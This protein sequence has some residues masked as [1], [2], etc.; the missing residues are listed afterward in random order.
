MEAAEA[1]S[2]GSVQSQQQRSAWSQAQRGGL[3]LSLSELKSRPLVPAPINCI[4]SLLS[5]DFTQANLRFRILTLP[6]PSSLVP[7]AKGILASFLTLLVLLVFR[8]CPPEDAYLAG[9]ELMT[10]CKCQSYFSVL[11]LYWEPLETGAFSLLGLSPQ[12]L[13]LMLCPTS[14]CSFFLS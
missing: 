12:H 8:G 10:L 2:H 7:S 4:S 11:S 9:I 5:L 6:T 1:S 3:N 14:P 13:A